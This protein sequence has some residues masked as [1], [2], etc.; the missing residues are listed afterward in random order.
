MAIAGRV[1]GGLDPGDTFGE[2]CGRGGAGQHRIAGAGLGGERVGGDEFERGAWCVVGGERAGDARRGALRCVASLGF[3]AQARTAAED[4]G[5]LVGADGTGPQDDGHAA[6]EVDDRGFEP[7]LAG[8]AVEDQRHPATEF[9][10]H[11]VGGGGADAAEAVGRG[12]GDAG[13]EGAQQLERHRMI[14]HPQ[15]DGVLAAGDEVWNA[16]VLLEDQ[17]ERAGPEGPREGDGVLGDFPRPGHDLPG[18]GQVHDQG[19]VR[20]AALGGEDLGDGVRVEGVGAEAVHRLGGQRD[21]LALAQQ[22]DGAL[23]VV[24]G[25]AQSPRM[26]MAWRAARALARTSSAS[27]PTTVKCP[28]LRPWRAWCLA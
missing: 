8:A 21:K 14:G 3:S 5:D 27:L 7:H 12:R 1:G 6:G 2:A 20:R 22:L 19:V 10:A 24:H 4:A 25:G 18:V 26:P 17:G 13:A 15:P 16:L 11:V 9:L 23:D 28:I